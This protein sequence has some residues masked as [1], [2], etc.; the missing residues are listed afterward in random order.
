MAHKA[1]DLFTEYEYVR[2]TQAWH[3]DL[4]AAAEELVD[5]PDSQLYPE[6]RDEEEAA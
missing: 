1:W 2:E 6:F 3:D 4:D 5:D